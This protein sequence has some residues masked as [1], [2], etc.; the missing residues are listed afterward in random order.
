MQV[1]ARILPLE[2]RAMVKVYICFHILITCAKRLRRGCI[3]SQRDKRTDSMLT[4][5][6]PITLVSVL[7]LVLIHILSWMWARAIVSV[8]SQI[9]EHIDLNENTSIRACIRCKYIVFGFGRAA[10]S[11]ITG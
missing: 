5:A 1:R 11:D 10:L 7:V 4:L 3:Y 6:I 9:W 8:L 2:L